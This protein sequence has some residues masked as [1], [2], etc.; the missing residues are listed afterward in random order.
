MRKRKKKTPIWRRKTKRM[1]KTLF[2]MV[3]NWHKWI[4]NNNRQHSKILFDLDI[5]QRSF[6]YFVCVGIF[7]DGGMGIHLFPSKL[8]SLLRMNFREIVEYFLSMFSQTNRYAP[9]IAWQKYGKSARWLHN[10]L[11]MFL[12]YLFLFLEQ[13]NQKRLHQDEEHCA[14]FGRFLN[15]M[16][17]RPCQL[18]FNFNHPTDCPQRK[19]YI[20][21][22]HCSI[23]SREIENENN[24]KLCKWTMYRKIGS[25]KFHGE[26]SILNSGTWNKTDVADIW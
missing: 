24:L 7:I 5:L 16:H 2:A 26:I 6:G 3:S 21:S 12:G 11:F 17:W 19:W 4:F 23:T 18:V 25:L 20:S 13:L 8:I 22:C 9:K 1:V 10:E 15:R 14:A